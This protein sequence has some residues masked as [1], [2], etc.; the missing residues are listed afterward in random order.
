MAG[1]TSR[2]TLEPSFHLR[3][4]IG[5]WGEFRRVSSSGE[6]RQCFFTCSSVDII[7]ASGITKGAFYHYFKSKHSLCESVIDEL[8]HDFQE[9]TESIDKELEPIDQLRQIIHKLSV[10]NASGEWVNC[11]LM[12]RLSIDSHEGMP[13]IQKKVKNFWNWY[14]GFYENLIKQC[15][16]SGQLT[17]KLDASLQAVLLM[18]IMTG[19]IVLQKST[20]STSTS[21]ELADIIIHALR[22]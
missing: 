8:I 18:S 16:E 20:S 6:T 9:L 22:P 4:T 5:D 17:D 15:Q 13:K 2:Q 7:T 1:A 3:S 14:S 11:R 21:A 10:L 19:S 12:L